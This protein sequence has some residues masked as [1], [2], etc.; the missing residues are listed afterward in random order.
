MSLRQLLRKV[1]RLEALAELQAQARF[2]GAALSTAIPTQGTGPVSSLAVQGRPDPPPDHRVDVG[3]QTV[4]P[5]YF[6]V[7][8][9]PLKAGRY[10]DERD[11]E[12][13]E[14]VAIVNEV[15]VAR[16]FPNENPIGK[17]IREYSG[18]ASEQPW[19]RVV[20]V[21]TGEKRTSV[22][23]EM[24][25]ADVPVIYHAWDQNPPLAA[26]LIVR[27]L[28]GQATAGGA[29][30]RTF[31]AI[32]RDVSVGEIEPVSA[33]VA[34][35]LAYPRFR[36]ITLAAFAVFALLLASIGLYGVLWQFVVQ[37]TPEIGVR[38]AMGARPLDMV[39]LIGRQAGTPLAAGLALG[40]AGASVLSRSLK[41]LLYGV[42]ASDPVTLVAVSLAL[43]ATGATAAFLPARRAAR[44]DP[45]TA[46]RNE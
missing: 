43:I 42:Q 18:A 12:Q 37:R 10:F 33:S 34:K 13:A 17:H 20:G 9:I 29:I 35:I 19:L 41:S 25:W 5:D 27:T 2:E 7:M 11:H 8:R 15:L 39:G 3:Q 24:S 44:V 46:L 38:M 4:S 23:N 22:S 36:A 1:G 28:P 26:T 31:V 45:M 21:V 16:Y 40:L 14:P 30:Q 6:R 32:D